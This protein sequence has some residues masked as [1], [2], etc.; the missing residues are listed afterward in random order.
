MSKPFLTFAN[1]LKNAVVDTIKMYM[2]LARIS[3]CL[4]REQDIGWAEC[5]YGYA[6]LHF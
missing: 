2:M 3:N 5:L 1:N 4:D 6:G